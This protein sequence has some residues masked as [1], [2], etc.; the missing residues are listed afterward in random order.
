MHKAT[1][2]NI[3]LIA[4]RE[5]QERVR[6]KAFLIFTLLT[7]ALSI[8]WGVLP[9]LMINKRTN[10]HQHLVVVA[11]NAQLANAVKERIEAPPSSN[12]ANK[13]ELKTPA[14][15]AAPS[16]YNVDIDTNVTDAERTALEAKIDSHQI[17]SFIWLD[18][19]SVSDHQVTYTGRSTADFVELSDLQFAVRDALMKQELRGHGMTQADVDAALKRFNMDTVQW[20]DGKE[21]KSNQ[22]IQF[23]S[24]FILG[25]VMYMTVLIFGMSVM[26]SVLQE[27]TSRIMEV[28][29]STVTATDLMAGKILGVGAVGLTQI[30]IWAAMAI[31]PVLLGVSAVSEVIKQANYSLMTGVWF[32]VF[33]LGGFFLY[34]S[35]CA[36]LG[37]MV[38]SEQEAQQIQMFVIMPL[39]LSFMFL[40]FAMK[41]PND[42]LV[43]AISMVPFAAP[44]IMITRIVVQT[45]PLWQILMSLAIMMGTTYLILL[46]TSRIYRVG[47]LMYGKR[48]NLPEIIK[49]IKYA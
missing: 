20:V 15:T 28:L 1:L 29:M 47:I 3:W 34:S 39:I 12:D 19:K 33:F 8:A 38:S 17:D 14:A 40:F 43:V 23:F 44:I 2:K 27:K 24:V 35:M 41:A 49:W 18:P 21:K 11:E 42:P 10:T 16:K 46:V 13:A 30:L 6:T 4:K 5:Y 32:A 45:P 7:P 31:V 25:F 9:T 37:A 26:R 22:G 48:P 36:A